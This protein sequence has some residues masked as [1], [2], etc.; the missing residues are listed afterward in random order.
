MREWEQK[1]GKQEGETSVGAKRKECL[2]RKPRNKKPCV[3]ERLE[4]RA[5]RRGI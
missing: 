3:R 2:V 1:R 5:F 4:W